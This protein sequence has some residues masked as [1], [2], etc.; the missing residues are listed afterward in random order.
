MAKIKSDF[1]GWAT[2]YNILCTDG[3]TI[4]EN[5]FAHCDG[6]VVPL[7]WN[8]GHGDVN[9]VLGHA[10]LESR[11]G[12]G[13]YAWCSLNDSESGQAAKIVVEHRDVNSLSIF[14]DSLKQVRTGPNTK[15]VM[16]GEI[17]ELSLVLAGANRGARIENFIQHSVSEDD[18]NVSFGEAVIF[19]GEEF[20][21]NHSAINEE[22][23]EEEDLEHSSKEDNVAEE[24]N[25][26]NKTVEDVIKS[27]TEEQKNVMYYLVHESI[28]A[29]A[30]GEADDD[31]DDDDEDS[32][33][34][35]KHSTEN[36]EGGAT[37][38]HNVFDK[39][40]RQDNNEVL[41][42]TEMKEIFDDMRRCGSLKESV[43]A[44]GITHIDYLFPE[45][46]EVN[47]TPRFVKRDTSWVGK[48]MGGVHHTPF[49]KI[50]ST[51]ADITGDDARAK[52]YIK[53]NQKTDEV[54][55]LLKRSTEPTTVYK[56]QSLDRDDVLD[57]SDFDAVSWLK[58]EMRL[59]LDEEIARAFL[60]GDGRS[61]ASNDKISPL[62]I[63]PIWTDD[64]FYTIKG[65]IDVDANTT[66]A[67]KA[68]AF[69]KKIIK[70]RK[71]Y[72]GSG[73]PT[74]FTT[75]D[76]LTECLLLEDTTGRTIYDSIDK[77][78]VACRVKEIVTVPT[79]DDLTRVVGAK[80]HTL[81]GIVVNL[82]DYFTGADKGGAV[83]M[84]DDF[85][86]DYN[87][88]KYLIETRCSGALVVPYSAI[89]IE[90][91]ETTPVEENAG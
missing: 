52:G 53:G 74:L 47:N 40:E 46:T 65:V 41:S 10:L 84:F 2:K 3:R 5:A 64:D 26:D 24:N 1:D 9:N 67:Q 12:E 62:K 77:L 37:M 31:N 25:S 79:M 32:N 7:V 83:N 22:D 38:K 48:V 61:A 36:N 23:D 45:A 71:N 34:T 35:A 88:Q 42:H 14:A 11:P 75:E 54:F 86:I 30:E 16:H 8:H 66:D 43:M 91:A 49:S 29:A 89:A 13:V 73:S 4:C 15:S 82:C 50:K 39:E 69:I 17:R 72:K 19:S 59:M 27:M 70:S 44:H 57:I 6:M 21:L 87:K 60:V 76:M 28:K 18:E 78:A 81:A 20:N 51:F 80:T 63:R 33:K 58:S 55:T 85:D 56:H 68:K 90:F